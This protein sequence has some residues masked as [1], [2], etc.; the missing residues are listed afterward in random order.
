MSTETQPMI[1]RWCHAPHRKQTP[2]THLRTLPE[3]MTTLEAILQE[4]GQT[5][6]AKSAARTGSARTGSAR[7]SKPNSPARSTD[8]D[9]SSNSLTTPGG[10]LTSP[11]LING[12]SEQ[13]I[14]MEIPGLTST[15]A[16]PFQTV[17]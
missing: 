17:K 6:P 13:E 4:K 2:D 7:T 3:G 1:C 9:D 10:D 8:S 5:M 11:A 12:S 16:Q 14:P 15:E